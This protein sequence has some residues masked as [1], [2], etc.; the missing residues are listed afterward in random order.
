MPQPLRAIAETE[1]A[2][3]M[4]VNCDAAA[5][6]RATPANPLDLQAEVLKIHRVVAV[7]RTFE[8]K[9]EDQIQ[10]SAPPGYKGAATLAG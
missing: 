7:D 3:Q 8:L 6:Q 4:L 5:G 10:I 1:G 9:R 2:I